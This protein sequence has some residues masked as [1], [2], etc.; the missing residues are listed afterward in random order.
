MPNHIV[1]R[2]GNRK[3]VV[4]AAVLL[5]GIAIAQTHRASPAKPVQDSALAQE[6]SAKPHP[7][8][9]YT[10]TYSQ[11]QQPGTQSVNGHAQPG[12]GS[13]GVRVRAMY[14]ADNPENFRA[15]ITTPDGVTQVYRPHDRLPDT[16]TEIV[17]MNASGVTLNNNG[18][19]SNVETGS[20]E[21]GDST[22]GNSTNKD[23][24][25]NAG[26]GDINPYA[27]CNSSSQAK[28]DACY[29]EVSR[30]IES[31]W[32]SCDQYMD[33]EDENRWPTCYQ[34]ADRGQ[35]Y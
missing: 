22:A 21:T 6:V 25:T 12:S 9:G 4:A 7:S 35:I 23:G 31:L 1:E 27:S 15:L 17:A 28:A 3:T 19:I 34:L 8:T 18:D 14:P 11:D 20:G 16:D 2:V 13:P 26:T 5:A 29:N 24:K 30:Y 33:D 10:I 32:N